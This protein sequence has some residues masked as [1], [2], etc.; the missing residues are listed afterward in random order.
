MAK[1]EVTRNQ[2]VCSR[3][4]PAFKASQLKRERLI[5]ATRY[6]GMETPTSKH[7]SQLEVCRRMSTLCQMSAAETPPGPEQERMQLASHK[8]SIEA[9]ELAV[10]DLEHAL[11]W[12]LRR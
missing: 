12:P 9:D 2:Q 10:Q 6:I 4:G 3:S 7:L 11:V 8:F 1:F 5:G